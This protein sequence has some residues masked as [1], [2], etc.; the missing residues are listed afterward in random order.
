MIKISDEIMPCFKNIINRRIG[1][2]SKWWLLKRTASDQVAAS[3]IRTR[4][5]RAAS[6]LTANLWS[7]SVDCVV[8]CRL[9]LQYGIDVIEV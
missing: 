8:F 6:K 5:R 7:S 2:L 9:L 3:R 1:D 4:T